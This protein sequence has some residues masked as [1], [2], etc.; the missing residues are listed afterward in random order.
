MAVCKQ[1]GD[2]NCF[3]PDAQA[4]NVGIGGR[5]IGRSPARLSPR[6]SFRQSG[7]CQ[8]V[9][10]GIADDLPS[11]RQQGSANVI[12]GA[13]TAARKTVPRQVVYLATKRLSSL[14]RAAWTKTYSTSVGVR[15][16]V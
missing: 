7:W 6:L 14:Y 16:T 10:F 12:H 5:G 2:R 15:F 13:Y 4:R 3:I 11:S 9:L 8:G 1:A